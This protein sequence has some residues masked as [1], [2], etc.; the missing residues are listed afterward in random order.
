MDLFKLKEFIKE[1]AQGDS[2]V[3]FKAFQKQFCHILVVVA[4][5]VMFKG[6]RHEQQP[7]RNKNK[8]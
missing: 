7:T 4:K 6:I 8:L 1:G 2:N 5:Y 3:F